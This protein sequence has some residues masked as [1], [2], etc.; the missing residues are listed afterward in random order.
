MTEARYLKSYKESGFLLIKDFFDVEKDI[1]PIQYKIHKLI[2][3]LILE[4]N[5]PIEITPFNPSHFDAQYVKMISLDRKLGSYIYDAVKQIPEFIR[6]I[7]SEKVQ[8]MIESLCG[9]SNIGLAQGGYGMRINNPREEKYLAP[10]HQEYPAQLRSLDGV[11]LWSPL[12]DITEEIGPVVILEGSH[13]E[14]LQPVISLDGDHNQAYF[15]RIKKENE[16]TGAYEHKSPLTSPGDAIFMNYLTVHRSGNNISLDRALW[17]MQIRYFNFEDEQGK[18]IHWSGGYN[19]GKD[20]K[21]FHP[22]F[23]EKGQD[24]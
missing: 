6:L 14:G 5:L 12:I 10:W 7:S 17:S 9:S 13:K 24:I 19:V 22:D 23:V 15:L 8:L 2:S 20:F 3:S 4:H 16:M 18:K 21:D 11:V 1:L